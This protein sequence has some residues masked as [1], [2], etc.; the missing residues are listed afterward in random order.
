MARVRGCSKSARGCSARLGLLL[1]RP[2]LLGQRVGAEAELVR[3]GER[4]GGVEHVQ[5]CIRELLFRLPEVVEVIMVVEQEVV[6]QEVVEQEVVEQEVV[7]V[8]EGW[9][10]RW[11]WE[12]G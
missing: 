2:P 5:P 12:G 4:R 1:Q 7:E 9:G 10:R 8:E 3:F 6:E 11:R